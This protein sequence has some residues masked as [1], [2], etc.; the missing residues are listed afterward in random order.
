MRYL[1]IFFISTLFVSCSGDLMN[2]EK[3]DYWSSKQLL[4][5]TGLKIY[6]FVPFTDEEWQETSNAYKLEHRQIPED[7]LN[8]MNS[9]DLFYQIVYTD[10]SKNMLLFNTF[11]Q[12]FENIRQMNMVPGL[13]NRSDAGHVLLGIL[14]KVTPSKI[15]GEDCFWFY[16]CLQIIL[17]QREVINGMTDEDI[18]NCITQQLRCHDAIRNLSKNNDNWEYP[19]S[20]SIILYGLGNIMIQY[21]FEPFIEQLNRN[22]VTNELIWDT[23]FIT[24]Q[25]ALQVIDY[26]KQFKTVL[27]Q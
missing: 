13:L 6:P 24:E 3:S 20:A 9:K 19:Q 12:G 27:D 14:Q 4:D 17:A 15:D 21:K 25:S 18:D 5:T 7:F 23:Q 26:I 10:L 22:P 1:I 11:Q 2:N 16:H 8:N